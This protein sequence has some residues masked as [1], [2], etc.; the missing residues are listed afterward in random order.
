MTA[1]PAA[2]SFTGSTVTEA[3]FKTAITDQREFLAALLGTDGTVSAA[4]QALGA[5]FSK[6]FSKTVNYTILE[7]D[8]GKLLTT[9]TSGITFTLP[10]AAAYSSFFVAIRNN[11]IAP[12][13]ITVDLADAS[14]ALDNVVGGSVTLGMGE[15]AIFISGDTNWFT[16]GHTKTGAANVQTFTSTGTWTKPSSGSLAIIECWGGGGSGG[17]GTTYVGGGGGGGNYVRR[18]VALTSLGATES[19]NVGSGG[20]AKTADGAGNSGSN[21]TFGAWVTAHGGQGG[22]YNANLQKSN[23]GGGGGGAVDTVAYS[24]GEGGYG[25]GSGGSGSSGSTGGTGD[26]SALGAG[27]GGASWSS[28]GG[29]GGNSMYGGAGGGGGSGAA[30]GAGGT[31]L[32]GGNGGAGSYNTAATAGAQPGGGGGGSFSGNS[33]AG[34][35]GKC[36]VT[37]I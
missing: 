15:A 37:V 21:T 2:S 14:D 10:D 8:R 29:A 34:G 9:T 33:G 22:G 36:V 20:G 17:R 7:A 31:S 11:R 1:L 26:D 19:V 12:G 4:Q 5:A 23:A 13:D 27:G 28:A 25:G 35:A 30:G 24:P 16:V 18:V 3:Q 32:H 6:Q